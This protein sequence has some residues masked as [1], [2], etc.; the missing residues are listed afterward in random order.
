MTA[1]RDGLI[2]KIKALLA[3]TTEAGCS[4]QEAMAAIE[5][6]NAL[7]AAHE[8]TET[9]LNLTKEEKVILRR[10]PPETKDPHLIKYRLIYAVSRF[11]GCRAWRETGSKA[12]TFCGLP[13]DAQL[14]TWMLDTLT[15]FVQ[16]ELVNHLMEVGPSRG[17]RRQVIRDFVIGCTDRISDRLNELRKQRELAA[18]P[19]SNARA[20]VVVKGAAIQAKL[21]ELGI[22]LCSGSGLCGASDSPSLGAGAAAGER[23]S[24]GRPV[25]GRNATLRLK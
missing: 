22:R 6:A 23:A 15:A 19:T 18:A 4:E 13:S 17:E 14:A 7:I 1:Q 25:S 2:Y 21:D 8:I 20:L 16:N 10:E 3:K 11:C 5:K 24:F 9:E 12:I